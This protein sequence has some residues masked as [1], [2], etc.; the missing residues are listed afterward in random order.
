MLMRTVRAMI[1]AATIIGL[2]PGRAST[3]D[4]SPKS[5]TAPIRV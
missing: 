5:A 1:G 2:L 4:A 3:D